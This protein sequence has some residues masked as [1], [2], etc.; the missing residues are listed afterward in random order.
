MIILTEILARYQDFLYFL[1]QGAAKYQISLCFNMP[2]LTRAF[3]VRIH[4]IGVDE[5]T[6]QYLDLQLSRM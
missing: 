4:I 2:S 5:D 1:H 6:D 3:S